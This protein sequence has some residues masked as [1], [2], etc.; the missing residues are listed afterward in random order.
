[1]NPITSK[2]VTFREAALAAGISE[3]MLRG[4]L[5]RKQVRPDGDTS[6]GELAW[7]RFSPVDCVCLKA[8]ARLV[9]YG[10][11]V[12]YA[13]KLVRAYVDSQLGLLKEYRNT[14]IEVMFSGLHNARIWFRRSGPKP[15]DVQIHMTDRHSLPEEK[16]VLPEVVRSWTDGAFVDVQEIAGEVIAVLLELESFRHTKPKLHAALEQQSE[17]EQSEEPEKQQ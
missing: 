1:M 16:F 2:T 4:W 15:N 6:R 12:E 3:G 13:H 7:R 10:L 14:P 17:L 8:T 11:Q 5:D 9:A